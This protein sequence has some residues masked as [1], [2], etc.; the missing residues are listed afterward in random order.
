MASF[1]LSIFKV[2]YN[3]FRESIFSEKEEILNEEIG[4]GNQ[5]LDDVYKK[6]QNA[7]QNKDLKLCLWLML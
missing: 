7:L 4:I 1:S 5:I 2:F 3:C 6:L